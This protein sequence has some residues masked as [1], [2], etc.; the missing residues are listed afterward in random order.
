MIHGVGDTQE[1]HRVGNEN[2]LELSRP[3]YEVRGRKGQHWDVRYCAKC[4]KWMGYGDGIEESQSP[5]GEELGL[6]PQCGDVRYQQGLE[7]R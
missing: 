4:N 1:G 2:L 5:K 3:D 7:G 6:G